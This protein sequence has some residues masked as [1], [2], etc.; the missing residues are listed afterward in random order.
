MNSTTALRISALVYAAAILLFWLLAFT[1]Q[2][3]PTEAISYAK[4]RISQPLDPVARIVTNV[5]ILASLVS[6]VSAV[7]LL[8]WVAAVRWIFL[9]CILYMAAAELFLGLPV[10]VSG[11][12]SFLNT[13][14]SIAAGFIVALSYFSAVSPRSLG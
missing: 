13:L 10:L 1:S 9:G 4:W 2:E 5:G 11:V 7:G 8:F 12:Q 6:L 3:L 14:G